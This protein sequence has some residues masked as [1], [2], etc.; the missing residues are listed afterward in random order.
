MVSPLG[1]ESL[2]VLVV[3]FGRDGR[4]VA[5]ARACRPHVAG[6]GDGQSR[7]R[8]VAGEMRVHGLPEM[9]P[10]NAGPAGED[11]FRAERQTVGRHPPCADFCQSSFDFT[12]IC[13]QIGAPFWISSPSGNDLFQPPA[14]ARNDKRAFHRDLL[15]PKID[16]FHG[17]AGIEYYFPASSDLGLEAD[18]TLT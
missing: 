11:F 8:Y 17:A 4:G 13:S 14:A 2:R 9:L 3:P 16:F 5:E 1:G 15:V 10:R 7:G 18:E 6:T 12:E